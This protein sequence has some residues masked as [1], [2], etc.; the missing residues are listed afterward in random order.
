MR[1][2]AVAADPY[3]H[4]V[5]IRKAFI[6]ISEAAGL[7]RTPGRE[8]LRVEKQHH[9]ALAARATSYV[10]S[11]AGEYVVELIVV[12]ARGAIDSDTI[13]VTM[14]EPPPAHNHSQT[15]QV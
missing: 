4:G 6:A 7:R 5:H 2:H 12:D 11:T 10:Y 3:H 13:N 8:I 1:L 14:K 15:T 9:V